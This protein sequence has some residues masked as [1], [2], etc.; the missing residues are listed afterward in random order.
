[1]LG[2]RGCGVATRRAVAGPRARGWRLR[3]GPGGSPPPP[4][5]GATPRRYHGLLVA[6]TEPPAGRTVLLAWLDDEISLDGP[7]GPVVCRL[8][9]AE[10]SDGTV[11]PEGFR[12]LESFRLD[13]TLP[14]WPYRVGHVQLEKR[15]WLDAGADTCLVRYQLLAAPAPVTLRLRPLVTCRDFH[16]ETRGDAFPVPSLHEL[17]PA[18][19]APAAEL[20]AGVAIHLS[21]D[22]AAPH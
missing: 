21:E 11:F 9:T 7:D 16:T 12:H 1:R 19:E 6:A 10:W 18:Q 15:L 22:S 17:R 14:V 4:G 20:A 2:A 3:S 13:G 5:R 8:S